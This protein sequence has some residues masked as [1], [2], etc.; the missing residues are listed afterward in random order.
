MNAGVVAHII[1]PWGKVSAATMD[2]IAAMGTV[3]EGAAWDPPA[4]THI[5]WR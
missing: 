1:A 5:C 3:L 4:G 2:S